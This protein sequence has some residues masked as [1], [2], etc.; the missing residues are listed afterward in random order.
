MEGGT[1]LICLIHVWNHCIDTKRE[2]YAYNFL[3]EFW[4]Y[5]FQAFIG[6][7]LW[8]HNGPLCHALSLSL[9][10]SILHCHLPGVATVARRLRNSYSYSW[11]RLILV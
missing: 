8:G 10:T 6:P 2:L 9:W 11:L 5:D 3:L 4:L 7:I 1:T